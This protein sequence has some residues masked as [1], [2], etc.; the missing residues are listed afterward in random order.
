MVAMMMVVNGGGLWMV[1]VIGRG[2]GGDGG[3]VGG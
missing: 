1:V 2:E 3:V